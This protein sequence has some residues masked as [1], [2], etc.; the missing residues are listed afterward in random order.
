MARLFTALFYD[1]WNCLVKNEINALNF[2]NW[3]NPFEI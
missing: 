2:T 3:I 1:E